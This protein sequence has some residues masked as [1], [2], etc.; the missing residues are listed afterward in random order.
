LIDLAAKLAIG[1][2]AI[3]KLDGYAIADLVKPLWS[4]KVI[5]QVELR[6]ID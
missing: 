1:D 5:D 3:S 2:C 6:G 4:E